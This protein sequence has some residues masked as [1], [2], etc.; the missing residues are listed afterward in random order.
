MPR[1]SA[2]F[3]QPE[4]QVREPHAEQEEGE[5]DGEHQRRRRRITP[6]AR[7]KDEQHRHCLDAPVVQPV[8]RLER[9]H[10]EQQR[11]HDA[12]RGLE[13]ELPKTQEEVRAHHHRRVHEEREELLAV[14]ELS[15]EVQQQ[16]LDHAADDEANEAE[17]TEAERH[18]V[19][20]L[21][22]PLERDQQRHHAV[23]EREANLEALDPEDALRGRLR[24]LDE[25][26][27]EV[28]VRIVRHLDARHR[29]P[30]CSR[31]CSSACSMDFARRTTWTRAPASVSWLTTASSGCAL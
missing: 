6:E 23:E 22:Q 26:H 13:A 21:T 7:K 5:P 25:F 10:H 28:P 17:H 19:A 18:T 16:D 27:R 8:D 20:D 14:L 29:M 2:E 12:G 3:L 30:S 4:R 1:P 15:I 31:P 11:K 24:L 9:E